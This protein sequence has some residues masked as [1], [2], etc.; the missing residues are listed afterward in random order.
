MTVDEPNPPESGA[1]TQTCAPGLGES[2]HTLG[3]ASRDSLRAAQAT[4]GA[5]RD[6]LAAD[7]ALAR[8]ALGRTLAL[9]IAATALAI[10]TWLLLM[11]AFVAGLRA[12]G[13]PWA[14]SLLIAAVVGAVAAAAFGWAARRCLDDAGLQATRRQLARMIPESKAAAAASSPDEDAPR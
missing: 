1:E 7:L 12:L 3:E 11:A 2:L 4:G 5:L 6:L 8:A 14:A 9:T 10:S 13:L